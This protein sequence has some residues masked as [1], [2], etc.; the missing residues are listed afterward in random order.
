MPAS[1]YSNQA[2][3]TSPDIAEYL[4]RLQPTRPEMLSLGTTLHEES[5]ILQHLE[6]LRELTR[7]K[8][9]KKSGRTDA[10]QPEIF[11]TVV[12][13]TDCYESAKKIMQDD[14]AVKNGLMRARLYLYKVDFPS[15]QSSELCRLPQKGDCHTYVEL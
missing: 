6:Y 10:N 12:L 4:Y 5:I 15:E 3:P 9:L 8:I 7:R 14:P 13:A 11:S 2:K 1:A